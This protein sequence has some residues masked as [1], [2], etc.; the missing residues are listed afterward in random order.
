[1]SNVHTALIERYEHN[2][3]SVRVAVKDL[4]ESIGAKWATL[5]PFP[6]DKKTSNEKIVEQ[7][8][9]HLLEGAEKLT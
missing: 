1:M 9:E 8:S 6:C 4:C 3:M 5:Q 2:E 7:Y